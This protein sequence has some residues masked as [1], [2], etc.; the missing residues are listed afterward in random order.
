MVVRKAR[1]ID[2]AGAPLMYA[3]R[4]RHACRLRLSYFA[5]DIYFVRQIFQRV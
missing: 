1:I 4:L 2:N 3:T 5:V